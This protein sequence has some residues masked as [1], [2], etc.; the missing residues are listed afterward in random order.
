MRTLNS[1]GHHAILN[2]AAPKPPHQNLVQ[3]GVCFSSAPAFRSLCCQAVSLRRLLGPVFSLMHSL[4]GDRERRA[5][6]TAP[7]RAQWDSS[8]LWCKGADPGDWPFKLTVVLDISSTP[9]RWQ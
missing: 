2:T 1:I 5:C 8:M 3:Y 9:Y 6:E 7:L 4:A